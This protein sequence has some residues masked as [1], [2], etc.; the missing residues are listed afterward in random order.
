VLLQPVVFELL[1]EIVMKLRKR[2]WLGTVLSWRQKL[3][4]RALRGA[5]VA[6]GL[7]W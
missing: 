3:D 2:N 7:M 6:F 5:M 4:Q 1:W